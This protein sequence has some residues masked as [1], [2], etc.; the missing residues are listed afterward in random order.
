MEGLAGGELGA[1]AAGAQVGCGTS[2]GFLGKQDPDDL[3][4]VPALGLGGGDDLGHGA[5]DV[6]EF[7]GLGEVHGI[8]EGGAEGGCGR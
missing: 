1:L 4:R 5:A 7:E 3:G 6:R 2:R 8:V